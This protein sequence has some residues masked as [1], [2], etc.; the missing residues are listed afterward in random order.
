[1]YKSRNESRKE[2]KGVITGLKGEGY[3][4][5]TVSQMLDTQETLGNDEKTFVVPP[6]GGRARM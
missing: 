1:M 3:S 5:K 2:V 4:F 6:S